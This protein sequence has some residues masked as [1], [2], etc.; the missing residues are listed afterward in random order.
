MI[1]KEDHERNTDRDLE[2]T[3]RV[4]FLRYY[5]GNLVER[6]KNINMTEDGSDKFFRN[7]A[8]H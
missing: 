2:G 1:L 3:G 6:L 8:N 7:M 4:L 5:S